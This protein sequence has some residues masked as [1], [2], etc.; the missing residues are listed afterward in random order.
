MEQRY[1]RAL[2]SSG[3][4][5]GILFGLF[6]FFTI[7]LNK[8][9]VFDKL[10][11]FVSLGPILDFNTA[12]FIML[13][14][15]PIIAVIMIL[16]GGLIYGMLLT[17]FGVRKRNV[18]LFSL[19][20]GFIY[21]I[22][23]NLPISR[24]FIVI[25]A[26]FT[27]CVFGLLFVFFS[28]NKYYGKRLRLNNI[29]LFMYYLAILFPISL[30]VGV[31]PIP[32]HFKAMIYMSLPFLTVFILSVFYKLPDLG[33]SFKP[34]RWFLVAWLL[35]LVWILASLVV[36]VS[37]HL[38]A[39]KIIY[40]PALWYYITLGMIVGITVNTVFAF[41]EEIGWRGLSYNLVKEFGFWK[42]CLIVGFVWGLWHI[43]IIMS[44]N[45]SV[46]YV[47]VMSGAMMLFAILLTP[48]LMF[49][50]EKTHSILAPAIAHSTMN[51]L[52]ALPWMLLVGDTYFY[53]WL[54][55]TGLVGFVIL[56]L[57]NVYIIRAR[58]DSNPRP[59][60]PKP[61]ALS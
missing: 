60:G 9:V 5:A 50:R 34:S 57:M 37:L 61:G 8:Q 43:P 13:V 22:E 33:L 15:V 38:L 51:A 4:V 55:I 2:I 14:T 56:I 18:L 58:G 54:S 35:P 7:F 17:Y 52:A 30:F 31:M 53:M 19:L 21:G 46:L 10:A 32:Y 49:F 47:T 29:R 6:A 59:P 40:S 44:Q 24:T 36:L 25:F 20:F 39:I 41:G 23:F 48:P 26:L 45:S 3:L 27:W 42:T 28:K 11:E 1:F 12:Y 16:I